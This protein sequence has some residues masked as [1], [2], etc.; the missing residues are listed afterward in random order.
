M[1]R[2]NSAFLRTLMQPDACSPSRTVFKQL[3]ASMQ[4]AC[5][6]A[7]A[8]D[9]GCRLV[10]CGHSLGGGAALVLAQ[11]L[12]ARCATVGQDLKGLTSNHACAQSC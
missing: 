6:H 7:A 1:G 9:G 2:V 8:A 11:L 5:A 4:A 12:F 10:L 3:E